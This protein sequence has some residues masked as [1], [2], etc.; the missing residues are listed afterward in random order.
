MIKEKGERRRSQILREEEEMFACAFS[1]SKSTPRFIDETVELSSSRGR[2]LSRVCNTERQHDSASMLNTRDSHHRFESNSASQS[3]QVSEKAAVNPRLSSTS[4]GV[5]ILRA[6]S[7]PARKS[8]HKPLC[9]QEHHQEDM[10]LNDLKAL[11]E[12]GIFNSLDQHFEKV[13]K[14]RQKPPGLDNVS[15]SEQLEEPFRRYREACWDSPRQVLTSI[16]GNYRNEDETKNRTESSQTLPV[17]NYGNEVNGLNIGPM[18][19]PSR[20][21]QPESRGWWEVDRVFVP[22]RMQPRTAPPAVTSPSFKDQ[23]WSRLDDGIHMQG[24]IPFLSERFVERSYDVHE[25][26]SPMTR[27]PEELPTQYQLDHLWD[28]RQPENLGHKNQRTVH[29]TSPPVNKNGRGCSEA[30]DDLM[31]RTDEEIL[32]ES[33]VGQHSEEYDD[34]Y[35]TEHGPLSRPQLQESQLKG[36]SCDNW[37][38][39]R[40]PD[41]APFRPGR[42]EPLSYHQH[43]TQWH[44]RDGLELRDFW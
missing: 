40:S 32:G 14:Y 30:L 21:L 37:A 27:M 24:A 19:D 9:E 2:P 26:L 23:S 22:Q 36:S 34:H 5:D 42:T 10:P 11:V 16:H 41:I 18:H 6:A 8:R 29:I 33:F 1:R 44:V 43:H 31:R 38:E 28:G 17:D 39:S 13:M 12:T 35:E 25:P 20:E 3:S 4:S 15:S 7:Y